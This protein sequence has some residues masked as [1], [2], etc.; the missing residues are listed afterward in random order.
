MRPLCS[1]YPVPAST[2]RHPWGLVFCQKTPS[3]NARW[4]VERM[5]IVIQRAKHP[6][7]K[8]TSSK[9]PNITRPPLTLAYMAPHTHARPTQTDRQTERQTDRKTRTNRQI[10]KQAN[11][12][13]I[14]QTHTHTDRDKRAHKQQ[15]FFAGFNPSVKEGPCC[16]GAGLRK[17]NKLVRLVRLAQQFQ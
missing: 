15:V 6:S 2:C 5:Y 8:G 12:C 3:Q 13:L 14:M 17:P 4:E 11:A 16:F 1:A 7:K 10:D 9:F